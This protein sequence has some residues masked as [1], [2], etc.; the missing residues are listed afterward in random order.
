METRA[1]LLG[2]ELRLLPNEPRGTT[3]KVT[4]PIVQSIHLLTLM[5]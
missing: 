3:V 2:G 1:E 4:V 5:T